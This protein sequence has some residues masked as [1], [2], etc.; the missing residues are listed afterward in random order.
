MEQITMTTDD[1]RM[2]LAEDVSLVSNCLKRQ[3][4]CV[5]VSSNNTL[6]TGWNGPPE[7]LEP[8]N[9]CP[10]HDSQ[11]SYNLHVC[12]AVHAEQRAIIRAGTLNTSIIGASIYCAFG[13]PC[14]NCL[15]SLI[16]AGI[17][18]IVCLNND[19]YDELSKDILAEWVG[20][21]GKFRIHTI[22]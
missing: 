6:I 5:I 10:R 18:E 11:S 9:P 21:G 22:T 7:Q 20:T 8:C 3:L 16:D 17:S 2:A 1:Y 14:K 12:R 13:I 19:Y 4:G 15:L